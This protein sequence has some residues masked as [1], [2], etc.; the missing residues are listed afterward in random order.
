MWERALFAWLFEGGSAEQVQQCLLCYKNPDK[1]FGHGMEHD[2]RCPDSHPLA[3]EYLLSMLQETGLPPG[4]LLTGTENWVQANQNDDGSLKNPAAVLEYPHAPWWNEGG[5]TMPDSIVGNLLTLHTVPDDILAKT[6]QWV[7]QNMTL[8]KIRETEWL[9]MLY[10]PFHYSFADTAFP[11]VEKYQQVTIERIIELAE[12]LP[13]EQIQSYFSFAPTPDSPVAKAAPEL[14]ARYLDHLE[15]SQQEEGH[16][17]DQH[18]LTQWMPYNTISAVANPASL[19]QIVEYK[20]LAAIYLGRLTYLTHYAVVSQA[21]SLESV[22]LFVFCSVYI[23]KL[24]FLSLRKP[25]SSAMHHKSLYILCVSRYLRRRQQ[26][27]EKISQIVEALRE[28]KNPIGV[29]SANAL[30]AA[31]KQTMIPTAIN[32][33]SYLK[34]TPWVIGS[35]FAAFFRR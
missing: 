19:W 34:S 7:T 21:S 28:I 8:E 32:M 3:L 15:N 35:F 26:K 10:H 25:R 29:T 2:I 23:S 1:G 6:R 18:N 24:G 33:Y 31:V 22:D 5:Q 30:M 11:D 12:K 14:T 13:E 27:C 9:F 16:W 4:D 20:R 17:K